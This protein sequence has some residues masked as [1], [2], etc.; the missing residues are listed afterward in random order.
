MNVKESKRFI[1]NLVKEDDEIW[2]LFTIAR[3]YGYNMKID[4]V[5][6]AKCDVKPAKNKKRQ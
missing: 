6:A 1:A 4:I 5:E 3:M 2:R